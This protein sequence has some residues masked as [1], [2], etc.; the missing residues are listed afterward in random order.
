MGFQNSVFINMSQLLLEWGA[1]AKPPRPPIIYTFSVSVL[2]DLQKILVSHF[3][4]SG[5]SSFF[6][7]VN[8]FIGNMVLAWNVQETSTASFLA[9]QIRISACFTCAYKSY[10]THVI[11]PGAG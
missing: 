4:T 1:G 8:L 5:E 2:S 7:S 9:Y 11:S 10:L 6:S 3:L